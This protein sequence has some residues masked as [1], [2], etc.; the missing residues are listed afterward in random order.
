MG[1]TTE[2]GDEAVVV[3]L[4][5][6]PDGALR[7][8][9]V[10]IL[11]RQAR[12]RI[13]FPPEATPA[14][15]LSAGAAVEVRRLARTAI[16]TRGTV[17]MPDFDAPLDGLRLFDC[18]L[19]TSGTSDGGEQ[20]MLRF[21]R[22]EGALGALFAPGGSPRR[23]FGG[24]LSPAFEAAA[25]EALERAYLPLWDLAAHVDKLTER[26]ELG[27][28]SEAAVSALLTI[29]GRIEGLGAGRAAAAALAARRRGRFEAMEAPP[30]RPLIA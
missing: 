12:I 15:A 10:E 17:A 8:R 4:K 25:L 7:L 1:E 2:C 22:I 3:T 11:A 18:C 30:A 9:S 26:G 6:E 20:I 14:G 27:K 16:E 29:R 24:G 23:L 5:A 13:S 19:L 28:D 21:N